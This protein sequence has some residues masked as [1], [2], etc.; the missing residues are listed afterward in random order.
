MRGAPIYESAQPVRVSAMLAPA[1][2]FWRSPKSVL[3][4]D[5]LEGFRQLIARDRLAGRD[6]RDQLAI[7]LLLNV[8][9]LLRDRFLR[10]EL[11][12]RFVALLLLLELTNERN[13]RR[14]ETQIRKDGLSKRGGRN[15]QTSSQRCHCQRFRVHETP[16]KQCPSLVVTRWTRPLFPAAE[17][18]EG[19]AA[20]E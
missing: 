3:R 5:W 19:D 2:S 18:N 4:S 1:F 11:R 17:S 13:S 10:P 12:L 7:L 9:V 15:Q 16:A 20:P 8:A 6:S 14:R